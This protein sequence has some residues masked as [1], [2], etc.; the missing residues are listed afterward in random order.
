MHSTRRDFLDDFLSFVG[1]KNDLEARAVAARVLN[2][3]MTAIW[4]KHPFREY[5]SPV[6]LRLTLTVNQARY[7]LPDYVGRIG[8][9][10]VRNATRNGRPLTPR[11]DGDTE[12]YRPNQGTAAE[13][14]GP[15]TEYEFAGVS[16]VHTQP[17]STGDALEVVSDNAADVD[18]LAA[19]AGDDST[20]R[21]TR[22]QVRLTGIVA[23]AI[24]TWSYLD[25][26]GKAYLS[27]A[28]PATDL[29]S[30]RGTITLRKVAGAT[31]LQ[32]LF[33]Q[34]AS[35]EHPIFAVYPKP[36]SADVLLLPVMRKPKRFVHDADPIPD[37]WD[38]ALWEEA[39]IQWAVN[40]NEMKLAEA[41]AVPR[42][43]FRDLAMFDN[44]QR[45]RA[46][47]VPFG[48]TW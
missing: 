6:P 20:G 40:R 48:G 4:L 42:P 22:N 44:E 34:E 2:R 17:A 37:L 7:S 31:E 24:G 26:F 11:V 46:A 43:A 38:P 28:T 16:G 14:A 13:V 47:S 19:I 29:L 8:P 32:K 9:G 1:E 41:I 30:S 10:Q 21:W 27:T 25:E 23:V 18:I 35:H 39:L 12:A 45:G 5:R 15:P 3:A 36:S 33:A